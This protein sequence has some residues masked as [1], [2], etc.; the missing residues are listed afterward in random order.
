VGLAPDALYLVRPDGHVALANPLQ[1]SVVL[2]R[3]LDDRG[4]RAGAGAAL[5]APTR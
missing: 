2:E 3:Y 1:K 4:I 5:I